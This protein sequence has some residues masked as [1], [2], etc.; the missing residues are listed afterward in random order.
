MIEFVRA[1]RA[2]VRDENWLAGLALAL[3]LPDMCAS[4][5]TGKGTGKNYADW[6]DRYLQAEYTA[7]LPEVDGRFAPHVFL[8]GND[9]YAL[10]CALLHRGSDDI[11][12]QRARDVLDRFEFVA[13]R[14]G[15]F[16]HCNKRGAVLQLQ[17]DV[18]TDQVCRG[19]ERWLAGPVS[20]DEDARTRLS[21]LI[22]IR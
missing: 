11:T 5:E 20:T 3:T 6:F 15:L 1:T 4:V 18:F 9:C 19:V 2:A 17:V 16:A 13:P 14:P 12:D 22:E 10:R 7:E 21:K 8:S